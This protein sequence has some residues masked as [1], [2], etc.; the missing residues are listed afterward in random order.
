MA[1]STQPADVIAL[2]KVPPFSNVLTLLFLGHVNMLLDFSS[3]PVAI[4]SSMVN[5]L[6]HVSDGS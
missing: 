1:S 2:S 5:L 4:S 6:V 3:T